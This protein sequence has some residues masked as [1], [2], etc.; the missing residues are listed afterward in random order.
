MTPPSDD[1][2]PAP[3]PY[4]APPSARRPVLAVVVVVGVLGSALFLLLRGGGDDAPDDPG[5]T[6]ASVCTPESRQAKPGDG[7]NGR[8]EYAESPPDSGPYNPV[9]LPAGDSF[10]ER[11][12]VDLPVE[13]AVRSLAQGDVVVWY[14]PSGDLPALRDTMRRVRDDRAVAAPWERGRLGGAKYV[15]TAWG[16]A[17]RCPTVPSAAEVDAF[18]ARYGGGGPL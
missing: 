4:A 12:D 1:A 18:A 10:V 8:I 3:S 2:Y 13:R 16:V 7:R 6:V 14:D 11:S 15:L 9:P 5:P 17:H